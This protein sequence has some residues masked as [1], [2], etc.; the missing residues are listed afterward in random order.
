MTSYGIILVISLILRIRH[1][2]L[3]R[4]ID[5][6]TNIKEKGCFIINRLYMEEANPH[7]RQPSLSTEVTLCLFFIINNIFVY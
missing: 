1:S 6:T 5:S 4:L 7:K 2:F 3:I